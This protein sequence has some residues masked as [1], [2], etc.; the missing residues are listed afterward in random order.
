[1][2]YVSA[3]LRKLVIERANQRCEYCL[4]PQSA[5]LSTELRSPLV[6]YQMRSPLQ[7]YEYSEWVGVAHRRHRLF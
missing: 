2:T 4:F 6:K 3:H 5:A 7:E 1:M